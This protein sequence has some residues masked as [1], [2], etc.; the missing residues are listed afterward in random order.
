MS[1]KFVDLQTQYANH[2]DAIDEA[3][4]DVIAS[5]GFILGKQVSELETTLAEYV[6]VKHCVGCASGTDALVLALRALGIG[7]GDEVITTPFSWFATAE[8]IA[9]VGATPVFADIQA[10]TFN[11]DPEQVRGAI[12]PATK[13]IMPVSL[14]GQLSDMAALQAIADAHGLVLIEDGAQ[15]FGATQ[16]GR[17][18]G[19]FGMVGCTGFYPTKVFSCYGDG[20]AIFTDSDELAE[21]FRWRRIHGQRGPQDHA[22]IGM[23]SRLDTLQAAI[24]L[25][26]FPS[27]DAELAARRQAA[28]AYSEGLKDVCTVPAVADGNEHAYGVYTMRVKTV[29]R[30]WPTCVPPGC[31]LGLLSACMHQQ[32]VF[33]HLGY[34]T[35]SMP[36]AEQA[37]QEVMSLPMHPFR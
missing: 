5:G 26:K 35:G 34:A 3:I 19:S 6:G 14:Y 27:F 17:R 21:Q 37:S 20:G 32:P 4:Q 24:M 23:N 25:A 1:V 29:M 36:M 13:A 16:D 7:D 11:L 9:R 15:S 30:C 18:S 8:V 12:T 31:R 33:E 2:K 22:V 28:A 10:D